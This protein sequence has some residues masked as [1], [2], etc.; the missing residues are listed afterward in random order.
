MTINTNVSG[1][2]DTSDFET[3]FIKNVLRVQRKYAV[4]LKSM[5]DKKVYLFD[6]SGYFSDAE[7]LLMCDVTV[8]TKNGRYAVLNQ[9]TQNMFDVNLYQQWSVPEEDEGVQLEVDGDGC[10]I[11]KDT[12][13]LWNVG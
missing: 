5:T 11:W 7:T 13:L 12:Q 4:A 1:Q 10:F 2:E 8:K 9:A 3:E 6:S